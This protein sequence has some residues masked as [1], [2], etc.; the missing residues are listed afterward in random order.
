MIKIGICD[1]ERLFHQEIQE[2]INNIYGSEN[3]NIESFGSGKALLFDAEQSRDYD[4][5]I[6]DIDLGS[7][8][9]IKIAEAAIELMPAVQIIFMSG[10]TSYFIDV[11]QVEHIYFLQ[12]PIDEESLKK[13][14]ER[15]FKNMGTKK[16]EVYRVKS[17]G[18]VTTIFLNEIILFE[19]I[20]RKVIVKTTREE[21]DFYGTIA[22]IEG[23]LPGNFAKCHSSCIINLDRIKKLER[24]KA[25][26]QKDYEV[27]ISRRWQKSIKEEHINIL[28]K[29]LDF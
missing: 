27:P 7:E 25:I 5:L 16:Q 13:S 8:N 23:E 10:F 19:R 4:I 17:K 2:L 11:Y 21:I 15:A 29:E 3:I 18:S 9:G 1:D 20:G 14:L 6:M 12:K 26:M 22:N 24:T 28:K